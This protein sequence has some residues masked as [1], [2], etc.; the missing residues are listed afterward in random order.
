MSLSLISITL[1]HAIF[2]CSTHSCSHRELQ[3]MPS[4]RQDL[5][6]IDPIMEVLHILDKIIA[7]L[8][9]I[10]TQLLTQ[11]AAPTYRVHLSVLFRHCHRL[12][13]I[14]GLVHIVATDHSQVVRQQL[15]RHD[16]DYGL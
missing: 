5:P 7:I 1:Q 6:V 2:T 10:F 14:A 9:C 3:C 8:S 15:Q 11:S 4:A 13:Q 12:C 16:I